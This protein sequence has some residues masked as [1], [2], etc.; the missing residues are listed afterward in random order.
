[1]QW[2][3]SEILKHNAV[4]GTIS[5]AFLPFQALCPVFG[6][7]HPCSCI[8]LPPIIHRFDNANKVVNWAVFFFKPG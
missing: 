4:F 6:C 8:N 7:T 3:L 1:M 2:F 5:L